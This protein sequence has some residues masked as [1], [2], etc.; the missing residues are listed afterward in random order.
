MV[1]LT[2]KAS[3]SEVTG[4]LVCDTKYPKILVEDV[5]VYTQNAGGSNADMDSEAIS[6][7]LEPYVKKKPELWSKIKGWWHSHASME[8]FWSPIDEGNIK[9]LLKNI[10]VLVSIVTNDSGVMKVRVDYVIKKGI[11]IS[12]DDIEPEIV[13][14]NKTIERWSNSQLKKINDVDEWVEE[15]EEEESS[16]TK[17]VQQSFGRNRDYDPANAVF[18]GYDGRQYVPHDG[19][20][21]PNF[22]W[23]PPTFND[24]DAQNQQKFFVELNKRGKFGVSKN[25]KKKI[26]KK[27]LKQQFKKIPRRDTYVY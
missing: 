15:P 14:F 27:L 25:E 23:I 1:A 20:E 4:L 12:I 18:F 26:I 16:P 8:T 9:N 6:K 21:D 3:P 22:G 19:Y 7:A 24:L 13:M 5:L 2:K 17:V 10:K 11:V